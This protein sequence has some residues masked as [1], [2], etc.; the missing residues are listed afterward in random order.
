MTLFREKRRSL[1]ILRTPEV[2]ISQKSDPDE[3][4]NWLEV[5]GFSDK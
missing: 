3:V 5:K 4:K 1:E 2:Y